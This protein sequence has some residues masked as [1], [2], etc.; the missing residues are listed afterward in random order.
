MP[1][2]LFSCSHGYLHTNSLTPTY[3]YSVNMYVC[4]DKLGVQGLQWIMLQTHPLWTKEALCHPHLTLRV[5][6]GPGQNICLLHEDSEVSPMKNVGNILI[7]CHRAH[8]P[9]PYILKAFRVLLGSQPHDPTS[10]QRREAARRR[11]SSDLAPRVDSASKRAECSRLGWPLKP[12][13]TY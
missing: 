2:M 4:N 11:Q 12:I 7:N 10:A 3:I 6:E 1:E 13:E 5:T 9:S 8:L